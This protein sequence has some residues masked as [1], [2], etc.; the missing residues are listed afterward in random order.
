LQ[1]TT[2]AGFFI[3]NL[4]QGCPLTQ[5]WFMGKIRQK[6]QGIKT[7]EY[8]RKA[9]GSWNLQEYEVEVPLRRQGATPG[10]G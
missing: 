8:W 9:A 4:N 10:P 2:Y 3:G 1:H 7:T 6:L 5:P